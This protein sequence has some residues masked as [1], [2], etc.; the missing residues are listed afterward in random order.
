MMKA[1]ELLL[2]VVSGIVLSAS[3]SITDDVIA[4]RAGRSAPVTPGVWHADLNKA[5]D[6]A[7][8]NGLP[9]VAV[10]SNGDECAHCVAFENC[11]MSPAF[12]HWMVDS[13][14]VFYF[15]VRNDGPYGPTS[16]GQ[17]G[18][19]GS[20]FYWC[21]KN[22]NATMNWPYVR[23]YWPKGGVDECH[24]GSWYDGEDLG[25]VMRCSYSD[26]RTDLANFIAPGD[27]GTYNPGGRRIVSVLVGT[28]TATAVMP[29]GGGI[30]DGG[31]LK[32]F[33]ANTYAGGEF[34]FVYLPPYVD[35]GAQVER[36]TDRTTLVVP[37]TRE[38][39][40]AQA[41]AAYNWLLTIY[42]N[43]HAETNRVDWAAGE[44]TTSAS[45]KLDKS[46]LEG[47]SEVVSLELYS[48]T[49][50]LKDESA[51]WI[52]DKVENSPSNPLF[53]GE[54]TAGTLGWGEWTM[55]ANAA[56]QKVS[57]AGG[58]AGNAYTLVLC[59]GELWCP[60][61][62]K[63]DKYLFDT[64]EF[65]YWATNTHN[66]ALVVID[67]PNGSAAN[68]PDGTSACLLTSVIGKPSATWRSASGKGDEGTYQCG[69]A[70]QTRHGV[71]AA[72]A[73]EVYARNKAYAAGLLN[74]LIPTNPYRPGV[75]T[76]YALRPDGTIAG[77]I[78]EFASTSPTAANANYIT[79]LEELLALVDDSD[80]EKD[81]CCRTTTRA[82]AGS[83]KRGVSGTLSC[84]DEADVYRVNARAGSD[85]TFTISGEAAAEVELAVYDGSEATNPESD[86]SSRVAVASGKV[87]AGVSVFCSLPS[88]ECFV[89]VR[90]SDATYFKA[91]KAGSTV[92]AY[93]LKS[94][95]VIVPGE[96][97]QETEPIDCSDGACIDLGDAATNVWVRL[98][99]D[100]QYKFTGLAADSAENAAALSYDAATG[101]YTAKADGQAKLILA[102]DGDG[103]V[104]F[105]YQ[106]WTVGLVEFYPKAATVRERGDDAEHDTVCD[107][108]IRRTGGVSGWAGAQITIVPEKSTRPEDAYVW[109]DDYRWFFWPEGSSSAQKATVR[110]KAD[111]HAD[112]PTKLVFKLTML[113]DDG[114]GHACTTPVSEEEFVL[115]I[116]D[117]DEADSGRAALVKAGGIAI[118]ESRKV[119]AKG[120]TK[121]YELGLSRLGGS[122]SSLLVKIVR[123]GDAEIGDATW[124]PREGS[125][126]EKTV[127]FDLPEY[128]VGGYNRVEVAIVGEAGSKIDAKSKYLTIDLI[129]EGA[130]LFSDASATLSGTR[131]VGGS[132]LTV[133]L[134]GATLSGENVEVVK[135]SGSVAPG[136]TWSGA[137]GAT[138]CDPGTPGLSISGTPTKGGTYTAV[139]QVVQDGVAGGTVQVTMTVDDPVEPS[140]DGTAALNPHLAVTRTVSDIMVVDVD[141]ERLVGLL[142][143]TV[144][145]S[146]RLSGKYRRI[147]G[148]TVPLLSEAW[149]SCTAGSYVATMSDVYGDGYS[150]VVTA[151]ADGTIEVEFEDPGI[152]GAQACLPRSSVWGG[153]AGATAWKGYYTVSLPFQ[154]EAE[155]E[156]A[157]ANGTGYVAFKMTDNEAV[158]CGRVA[159]AGVMANGKAFSGTAT[160]E[161][162]SAKTALLP[163][164]SVSESDTVTGVF[165]VDK[166]KTYREVA[167]YESGYPYWRHDERLP[168][169]SYSGKLNAYGC[170][171]K[172]GEILNCCTNTFATQYLTFFTLA[173]QLVDSDKF[174]T[175]ATY[176]PDFRPVWSTNNIY[177]VAVKVSN[178]GG[179]DN[180][181]LYSPDDAKQVHGLT[182]SFNPDT[183]L[184]SGQLW[185]DFNETAKT[186]VRVTATYRGIVKPGWGKIPEECGSCSD[187]PTPQESPFITGTCF[188]SD[189]YEYE[190]N[191]QKRWLQVKRGCPFSIGVEE[192]Q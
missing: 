121:G 9:L 135:L 103:I 160:L 75:P 183:G 133:E 77:R 33:D 156:A 52:V 15:G 31:V 5:R 28:R 16:D 126:T 134:D 91:A 162:L 139:F 111:T 137:I 154:S 47:D 171:Y 8:A 19:H 88:D 175:R 6:Y 166:S 95:G 145:R 191:M 66:V 84:A 22:Q 54:R 53:V 179:V 94:D 41:K 119:V 177:A 190:R 130:A 67:I 158:R 131:Y 80:E 172:K 24:S 106:R 170:L 48:D 55:D 2:T 138:D 3:A 71:T 182:L 14:I 38:N 115:T 42:P 44:A 185:L 93:T 169:A 98:E 76:I 102:P 173:D 114:D 4:I 97:Y 32:G 165:S 25:A 74:K 62:A 57:D 100:Q 123:D 89:R 49:V 29:V 12:R 92:A 96:T 78:A 50:E 187:V 69:V 136:M 101:V 82:I 110:I 61:C 118:P 85:V 46:W 150:A 104:V 40:S 1:K 146:G 132:D 21:C 90:A 178:V 79:R 64:P 124:A 143:V 128:E 43:G 108:S 164:F 174:G 186:G 125:E 153:G 59:G 58:S 65:M 34:G 26:N 113:V 163:V 167:P 73:A 176:Y 27:Y 147:D 86:D 120:G 117:D 149:D 105:G 51:I 127:A 140:D 17:E 152:G 7:V 20:S 11:I 37:L 109:S 184:V 13:G 155:S 87:S 122:D 35:G 30:A 151:K 159:Y 129:P 188:F 181:A 144:P 112:G 60:D 45:V 36:G 10:W 180:V 68:G 107:I 23:V 83:S 142:T 157:F 56:M 72:Q 99:K 161:A 168:E 116:I 18:Y 141:N 189:T 81:G 39:A 148:S 192:G 63:T 70:Y